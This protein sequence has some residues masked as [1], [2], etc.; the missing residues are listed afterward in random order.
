MNLFVAAVAV[1][2]ISNYTSANILLKLFFIVLLSLAFIVLLKKQGYG[3]LYLFD[4]RNN[5]LLIR[6]LGG[7]EFLL[8][9]N[10]VYSENIEYGLFKLIQLNLTAFPLILIL[11]KT[12]ELRD[13]KLFEVFYI[14][15]IGWS[16]LTFIAIAA[17]NPFD[18]STV[19]RFELTRWSHVILG[20]FEFLLLAVLL[21]VNVTGRYKVYKKYAFA[22]II[23]MIIAISVTG[24]RSVMLGTFI[25]VPLMLLIGISRKEVKKGEAA[26][27]LILLI[28]TPLAVRYFISNDTGKYRIDTLLPTNNQLLLQDA[29]VTGRMEAYK[30]SVEKFME[31]PVIG[32][33]LGGYYKPADSTGIQGGR[34]PHNILLEVLAEAGIAGLLVLGYLIFLIIAKTRRMSVGLM[35]FFLAALYLAMFSKDIPGNS[36]FLLGLAFVGDSKSNN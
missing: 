1:S 32:K 28:I 5:A 24:L 12:L 20:R 27:I 15:V 10:L 7:L 17:V 6:L 21:G 9:L 25:L 26:L 30:F 33:G 35:V 2:A 13:E 18:Q 11:A 3:I 4:F 34:Y 8:L 16:I 29:S 23:L 14:S 36:V 19:Y 22:A 31:S